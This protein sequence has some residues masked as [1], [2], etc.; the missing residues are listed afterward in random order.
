MRWIF[1]KHVRQIFLLGVLSAVAVFGYLHWWGV[2]GWIKHAVLKELSKR[3]INAEIESLTFDPWRGMVAEQVT[4]RL[5]ASEQL[6]FKADE[7]R[8]EIGL[9]PLLKGQVV[10]EELEFSDSVFSMEVP[11]EDGGAFLLEVKQVNGIFGFDAEQTLLIKDLRFRFLNLLFDVKGSLGTKR[12]GPVASVEPRKP[13]VLKKQ[14]VE[15]LENWQRISA[16][17][18]LAIDVNIS[19][20]LRKKE[21]IAATVRL[22]G[23]DVRY[24]SLLIRRARGEI[25][26]KENIVEIDHLGLETP[27]GSAEVQGRY[28]IETKD[29]DLQFSGKI[30]P[31]LLSHFL[32]DEK[33]KVLEGWEPSEPLSLEV[34]ARASGGRWAEA[35][36]SIQI[37]GGEFSYKTVP[38][39]ELRVKADWEGGR[40]SVPELILTRP[41]AT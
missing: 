25:R 27:E 22:R 36:A 20:D 13:V 11:R 33:Q 30:G 4:I 1:H 21:S 32:P 17:Q 28:A 26:C 41:K 19:G 31:R 40:L 15:F 3:G 18:L 16:A 14:W 8:L 23:R 6:A 38:F 5:P 12:F 24:G 9:A 2:P 37:H 10:I 34:S 39:R 7:V 29:A 35:R